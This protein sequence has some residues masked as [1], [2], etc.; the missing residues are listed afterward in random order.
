MFIILGAFNLVDGIAA[1]SKDGH[2]IEEQ[3]VVGD[4]VL[5]GFLLV[6]MAALQLFTG[7][8]L[9]RRSVLGSVLGVFLGGPQLVRA[10]VHASPR[11]P[12]GRC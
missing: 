7:F 10:V 5:W 2:F 6:T 1:L 11:S 3:L 8:A 12:P 9:Y 4:L